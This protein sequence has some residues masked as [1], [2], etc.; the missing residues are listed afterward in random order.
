MVHAV[1]YDERVIPK[2]HEATCVRV[3]QGESGP[4]A[5]PSSSF[6]ARSELLNECLMVACTL[7]NWGS[8]WKRW[9]RRIEERMSNHP[10]VRS[11]NLKGDNAIRHRV[12]IFC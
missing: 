7:M 1:Q 9:R 12:G 8:F 5:V 2:Y 3:G 11:L 6:V 10:R 4:W